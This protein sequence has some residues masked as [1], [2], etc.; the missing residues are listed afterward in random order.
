MATLKEVLEEIAPA[1]RYIFRGKNKPRKYFTFQTVLDQT[2]LSAD[3]EEKL[4]QGTYRVTLFSKDDYEQALQ[5]TI[6]KLKAAGYYI[7]YGNNG[8]SYEPD[9]G[10]WVVPITIQ[11]LKE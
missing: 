3:D 2:A 4:G 9:T 7:Q 5:K 8:E 11:Q 10:Y 1:E 6:E